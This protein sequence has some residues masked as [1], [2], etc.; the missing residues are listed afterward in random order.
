MLERD[1]GRLIHVSSGMGVEGRPGR[2]AY[3]AS[4]HGLEGFSEALA[5][6]L[7]DTGV[8]SIVIEPGGGVNTERF[9]IGMGPE[10]MADRLDPAVIVEPLLDLAAGHGTNG[11]RYIADE[12]D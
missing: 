8:S 2:S 3:S 9:T 4:K 7:S 5:A 11:S 6:E 12:F 10:E 1:R